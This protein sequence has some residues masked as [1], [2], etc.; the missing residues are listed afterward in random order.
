MTAQ[1]GRVPLVLVTGLSGAGKSSALNML[2]DLGFEAVDNLPLSL[3]ASLAEPRAEQGGAL[4]LGID[5][6]TRDFDAGRFLEA[7]EPLR[8]NPRL[9]VT[10][11]FLDADDEVLR[12]RFT[13]TRRRH[14][15]AADRP[16][17]DGIRL[18]RHRLEPLRQAADLLLDSSRLKLADLKLA[19]SERFAIERRAGLS[20]FVTSF[21]YRNGLPREADLVFDVRFLANP[22]Y[23]DALRELDGRDPEVAVFI[24]ADSSYGPFF[25]R[26][27]A[28]LLSLLPAYEREGKAYLT[29]ALGCTGGRH[30]SV[31]VAEGLER[32][33]A[34]EGWHVRVR[35]RDLPA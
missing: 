1:P 19:L 12:R 11:L 33:L 5:V 23:E 16:V 17:A 2:E 20:V 27:L 34:R 4:A 24:A 18:E 26:L 28:M 6:R 31:F 3:L 13:E 8:A 35:H 9:A 25:A 15:L 21:S 10:L 29:I 30:R 14:P 7:L 22:H 32:A